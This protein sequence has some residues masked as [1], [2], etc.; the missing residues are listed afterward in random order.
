MI[1][2]ANLGETTNVVTGR[3]RKFR[4]LIIPCVEMDH[5][6]LC[7]KPIIGYQCTT[8]DTKI[9]KMRSLRGRSTSTFF[10]MWTI[11]KVAFTYNLKNSLIT[12]IQLQASSRTL[13]KPFSMRNVYIIHIKKTYILNRRVGYYDLH[14]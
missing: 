12:D 4:S 5:F 11:V 14:I 9:S 8:T 6:C 2:G 7:S 3:I 1:E 10:L 13:R